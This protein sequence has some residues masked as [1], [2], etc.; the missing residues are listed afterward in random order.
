M[1][2]QKSKRLGDIICRFHYYPATLT[3]SNL[4]YVRKAPFAAT[5]KTS[6]RFASS[7]LASS[8]AATFTC[9]AA[10]RSS[11]YPASSVPNQHVRAV[12][13]KSTPG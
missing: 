4:L 5:R 6:T 11:S 7:L 13:F 3:R 8:T 9:T 1:R 12:W 10:L 2:H